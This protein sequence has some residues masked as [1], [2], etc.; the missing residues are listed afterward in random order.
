MSAPSAPS[1]ESPVDFFTRTG[2]CGV[3]GGPGS[4][5]TC[6]KPCPC[7]HLHTVGSGLA[8]D[9]LDA[10]ADTAPVVVCD[11]QEAMF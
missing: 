3:C 1:P 7:A 11:E 8:D 6:R 10:F 9:A 4:Y 2:H 5:C